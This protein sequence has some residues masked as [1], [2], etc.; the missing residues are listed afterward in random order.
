MQCK[1]KGPSSNGLL[2]YIVTFQNIITSVIRRK[3]ESQ[4]GCFKK[5]K[6]IKFSEKRTFLTVWY[7][8]VR[9]FVLTAKSAFLKMSKDDN[10]SAYLR[11]LRFAIVFED[12]VTAEGN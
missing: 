11:I 8:H 4:N 10:N 1:N 5:T 2:Q 6:H 7:A 9:L 3:G 12:N